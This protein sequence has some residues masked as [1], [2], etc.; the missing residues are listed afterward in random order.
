MLKS[1]CTAPRSL[2]FQSALPQWISWGSWRR[3]QGNI[4]HKLT[5]DTT[6]HI[7]AGLAIKGKRR[8]YREVSHLLPGNRLGIGLPLGHGEWLPLYVLFLFSFFLLPL[9]LLIYYIFISTAVFSW[10]YSSFPLPCPTEGGGV[11]CVVLS[12]PPLST[13]KGT[14]GK[15]AVWDLVPS[16]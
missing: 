12:C 11:T 6:R 14:R 15:E 16:I 13:H 3:L 10:F 2:L 9:H 5:R 4:Q 1:I 7:M 8:E